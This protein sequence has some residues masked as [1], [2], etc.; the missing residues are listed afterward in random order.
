LNN[1]DPYKELGLNQN[2]S[3]DEIKKSYRKLARK[4]HP[5]LNPQDS[6]SE[7][8]FKRISTA[9]DIIGDRKKRQKYD[10]FGL[11]G[12]KDGFNPEQARSYQ[13]W[14]NQGSA[15]F[16]FDFGQGSGGDSSSF[17]GDIF[18]SRVQR[19]RNGRNVESSIT[20]DFITSIRGKQVTLALDN[21]GTNRKRK[22]KV[23]I[24][25]GVRNGGKI[26]LGGKGEPGQNGGKPGDLVLTVQVTPDPKWKRVS[27]HLQTELA[28]TIKEA[29][30]GTTKKFTSAHGT[31]LS[32]K[33]PKRSQNRQ[34]LRLRGMGIP[35]PKTGKSGDLHVI[36]D[37]KLPTSKNSEL[38][39]LANALD[40]YYT[41]DV[42]LS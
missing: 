8:R 32:L 21:Q 40:T 5:D 25:P 18:G 11:D 23:K 1:L 29:V 6:R 7:E 39:D 30:C 15:G 31:E 22:L 26:R 37:V 10:E 42:D 9:F 16:P 36:L 17:F 13:Q 4:Y 24:P 38:D 2:A 41:D 3:Q 33:I 19:P 20:I 35:D 14:S 34:K 27:N 28:V 12:L